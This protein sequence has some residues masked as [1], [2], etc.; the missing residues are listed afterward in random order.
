M[1]DVV[2]GGEISTRNP[3]SNFVDDTLVFGKEQCREFRELGLKWENPLGICRLVTLSSRNLLEHN[4]LESTRGFSRTE[5]TLNIQVPEL[6]LGPL[7]ADSATSMRQWYFLWK[8]CAR[9][10]Q[11]EWLGRY[12][13]FSPHR[14]KK[15]LNPL[16]QRFC[17]TWLK[18]YQ[19]YLMVTRDGHW[20]WPTQIHAP[21]RQM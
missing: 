9:F 7:W 1:V 8:L 20:S 6:T 17:I 2:Q 21:R 13:V 14:L 3:S 11:K 19:I 15:W 4:V 16:R 5:L 18:S 10:F 12:R